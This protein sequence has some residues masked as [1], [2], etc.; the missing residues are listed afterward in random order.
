MTLNNWWG[1]DPHKGCLLAWGAR[2]I[3]HPYND[4]ALD[5]LWDRQGWANPGHPLL[6]AFKEM[7]NKVVL[8]ELQS[9]AKYF[10]SDSRDRFVR[11]FPGPL[12]TVV[13]AEGSPHASYGYFYLAVSVMEAGASIPAEIR[14]DIKAAA[15]EKKREA[16]YA[17]WEA[18]RKVEAKARRAAE[19][20]RRTTTKAKL[21][22]FSERVTGQ[23]RREGEPLSKGDGLVVYANQ[24]DRDAVV[25]AVSGSTALIEY[26]MPNGNTH[27]W[28]V[29]V[30][31]HE[32]VR[33]VNKAKLPKKW[34]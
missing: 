32:R 10:S 23:Y 16:A 5:F 27:L 15:D 31:T 20:D 26:I 33:N 9:L 14:P 30:S 11:H 25:L 29:D 1:L 4:H 8:P 3:F 12:G 24:A 34:L 21:D 18:E 2:A 13:V 6:A 22:K 28:E 7:L 19:A 17:E